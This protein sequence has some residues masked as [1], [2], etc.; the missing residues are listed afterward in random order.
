MDRKALK[1]AARGSVASARGSVKAVTGIFLLSLVAL[2]ALEWGVTA[3]IEHAPS[4]SGHYLSQTI[5]REVRGSVLMAVISLVFQ[6]LL[7]MTSLGYG[8]VSLRLARGEAFSRD[9][10][11]AGFRLWSRATLLY[12]YV[13]VLVGLLASLVSMPLSYLLSALWMSELISEQTLFYLLMGYTLLAMLVISY[14]YRM[15]YFLLLDEPEMPVRRLAAKAVQLGRTRRVSLFLLDVSFLPWILLC[16]ATCGILFLWKLPYITATYAH[17]YGFLSGDLRQR[18]RRME[19][20]LEDQRRRME[21][22]G[23]PRG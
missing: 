8:A 10:L 2:I 16:L 6:L 23:F 3:L 12:V 14:R 19:E 7:V 1:A 18:Q 20:L 17:A 11:L 4:G 13:S 22:M 21:E 9:T 5:S 15:V